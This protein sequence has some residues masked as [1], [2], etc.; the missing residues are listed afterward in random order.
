MVIAELAMM[1]PQH[2]CV[3]YSMLPR[4]CWRCDVFA[5][6]WADLWDARTVYLVQRAMFSI[7][8]E[9]TRGQARCRARGDEI[10]TANALNYVSFG[11]A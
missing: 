11:W 7:R 10:A 6:R 2:S 9:G 5:N 4:W 3:W 1:F 8:S